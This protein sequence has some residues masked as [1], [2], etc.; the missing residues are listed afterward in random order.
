MLETASFHAHIAGSGEGG[1]YH[2]DLWNTQI[3]C[4]V[5]ELEHDTLFRT[6]QVIETRMQGFPMQTLPGREGTS[7][8]CFSCSSAGALCDPKSCVIRLPCKLRVMQSKGSLLPVH[9]VWHGGSF[10][11]IY[12][13]MPTVHRL[14]SNA[15][16]TYAHIYCKNENKQD[17]FIHTIE[18]SRRKNDW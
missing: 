5:A 17:R 1:R 6:C 14:T 7:G 18:T 2:A 9:H 12:S 3:F 8:T 15:M 4:G 11:C 16:H 13:F 10:T